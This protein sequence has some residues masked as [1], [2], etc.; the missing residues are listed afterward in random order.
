[1]KKLFLLLGLL[2]SSFGFCETQISNLKV[3]PI[4]P[5]GKV[6]VEFDVEGE[7]ELCE[8]PWWLTCTEVDSGKAYSTTQVATV[9]DGRHRLEWDMAADGIRLDNKAVTFKVEYC[10][11]YLVI[12]LSGGTTATNYPVTTLAAP[13]EGGWSDEYKTTKL[14]LRVIES[15]SFKM[16]GSYDITISK[17]FYMGVFE[18]TQKQYQ[19]VTGNNPSNYQGD[20]RPVECVSWN[21]I[22]GNS[23]TYNWPS[24]QTVDASSF[25]GKLRAKTGLELDL[26][27]EAQWEYACRAGTTSDYNNGGN[28]KADLKTLG[29][30]SGNSYDGRG[31]YSQHTKVGAYLPNAWGLYDMHGNVWEWCLDW[32]GSLALSTDPTGPSSGSHRVTR[33]GGWDGGADHG[34]SSYRGDDYPSREFHNDGFRL[35][36]SAE[37]FC[38][39]ESAPIVMTS[40]PEGAEVSDYVQVDLPLLAAESLQVTLDGEALFSSEKD[41]KG[42]WKPRKLGEQT[43]VYTAGDASIT[44]TVD[45]VKLIKYAV[46]ATIVGDGTVA[47]LDAYMSD[48]EVTLTATPDEGYVFCGWD[49]PSVTATHTFT[50]PEEAVTVTAYFAS[51]TALEKYIAKNNL[52]SK[53]EAKQELLND[54]E[55]FTEDEMKA[56][57]LGAPMIKVKD[58]VATVSIQVQKASE[59]NGEWEVVEDGEVEL[60]IPADE[61]AA[62]YKFVV[63]VQQPNK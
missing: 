13:P 48:S 50:M 6:I 41:F 51:A 30:Y 9:T 22:R 12:D 57:A 32:Y 37:E 40:L 19:L 63:P 28:S 59:L 1:M 31:G 23:S 43:L 58:G 53:D 46:T 42:V 8:N 39:V 15:G 7:E 2:I 11:T 62:F 27:T 54:D 61:K 3:T 20:A 21:T 49:V 29:R 55:V 52:M 44:R 56:L 60:D 10:P 34:T 25:M 33:G 5:F 47:G 17:P 45:V 36:W 16:N 14:V 24:N 18:V 4:S 26:P 35:A 38:S